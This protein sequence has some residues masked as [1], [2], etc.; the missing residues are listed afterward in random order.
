MHFFSYSKKENTVLWPNSQV[1][2]SDHC[3]LIRDNLRFLFSKISQ[4]ALLSSRSVTTMLPKVSKSRAA[5][6]SESQPI[7]ESLPRQQPIG[8]CVTPGTMLKVSQQVKG[9]L[10]PETQTQPKVLTLNTSSSERPPAPARLPKT[11]HRICSGFVWGGD[12]ALKVHFSLSDKQE[13]QLFLHQVLC[14]I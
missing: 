2:N 7:S 4:S 13:V 10:P 8:K 9:S 11:L 12:F 3:Q 1:M 14:S 6:A 5:Q